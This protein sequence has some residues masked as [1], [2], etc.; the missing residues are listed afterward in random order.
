[1]NELIKSYNNYYCHNDEIRVGVVMEHQVLST[2]SDSHGGR[3][4]N[5]NF[6]LSI[7]DG[8]LNLIIIFVNPLYHST[9]QCYAL[10]RGKPS[11]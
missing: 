10:I 5:V 2:H 4:F 7:V 8:I 11:F 3:D 1:M 9:L 6:I